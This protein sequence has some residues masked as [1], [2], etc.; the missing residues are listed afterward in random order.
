[1]E[2]TGTGAIP[3]C[4]IVSSVRSDSGIS[5]QFEFKAL[6]AAGKTTHAFIK[7]KRKASRNFRISS[8][9][10]QRSLMPSPFTHASSDVFSPL[11]QNLCVPFSSYSCTINLS[12]HPDLL[13]RR[14]VCKKFKSIFKGKHVKI[15]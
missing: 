12:S 4:L 2:G 3:C 9:K 13:S 5:S 7:E 1:M 11:L 6:S 15:T 14:F 8:S 10:N